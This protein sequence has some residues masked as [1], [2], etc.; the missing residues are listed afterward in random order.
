MGVSGDWELRCFRKSKI[1][2]QKHHE[3]IRVAARLVTT[4][5]PSYIFE[6]HLPLLRSEA[7][8]SEHRRRLFKISR[9]ELDQTKKA[10][11]TI[12]SR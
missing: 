4:S 9:H 2:Q 10:Q 6:H 11:H 1:K 12:A 7:C 3:K 5:F 8:Q